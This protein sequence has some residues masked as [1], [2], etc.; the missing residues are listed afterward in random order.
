MI[1]WDEVDLGDR[2]QDFSEDQ[3]DSS[4][5]FGSDDIYSTS[6][7]YPSVHMVTH[8]LV[9]EP[10]V[11]EDAIPDDGV[12]EALPTPDEILPLGDIDTIARDLERD[13]T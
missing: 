1:P 10:D 3:N 9:G 12:Q 11:E 2:E 13:F 8:L 5:D 4:T 7:T 6:N